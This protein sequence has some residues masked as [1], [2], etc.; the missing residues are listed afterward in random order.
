MTYKTF[1]GIRGI[2]RIMRLNRNILTTIDELRNE[3]QLMKYAQPV[4][5]VDWKLHR[6]T[7]TITSNGTDKY[8]ILNTGT[9]RKDA[10]VIF[11][12]GDL[13]FLMQYF[14]ELDSPAGVFYTVV[15]SFYGTIDYEIQSNL[16]GTVT[17]SESLI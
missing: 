13:D 9:E 12:H 16:A 5:P 11:T 7:G 15:K 3:L 4:A 6:Y 8:L 1:R 17:V 10:I 14:G 2:R